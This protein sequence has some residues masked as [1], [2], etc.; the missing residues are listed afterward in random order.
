MRS[1]RLLALLM[2][3]QRR[4]HSTAPRLAAELGVSV[5]TIYRDLAAL[6]DAGVPLWTAAGP[7]GGVRLIE[8]WRSPIDGMTGDEAQALL[9]GQAGADLG[10]ASV[11]ATARSKVRSGLPS[12]VQSQIDLISERFLADQRR[13]FDDA[14]TPTTL[15]E[16]ADAVW[17]GVRIDLRYG[18]R[19]ARRLVDPL[20]LVVKAGVWYLVAAHRRQPRTYRVDRIG[21][22]TLRTEPA[23]RPAGFQLGSYWENAGT[24]ID[25]MIRVIDAV[26]R[27]PRGAAIALQ[28]S[29]PGPATIAAVETARPVDHDRLEVHLGVEETPIAVAMLIGVPGVE[30]VRPIFLRRALHDHA[31]SVLRANA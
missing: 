14:P 22:V 27:I 4:G 5:R 29:V 2:A 9:L 12:S 15:P 18:K 28:H 19:S 25:R 30:V 16:L 7:G 3:I 21:S 26:I 10:L 13:W 31:A 11:L 8:G 6:Q 23:V 24:E 17:R 1:S 20:G